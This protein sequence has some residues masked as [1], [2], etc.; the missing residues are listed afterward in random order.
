MPL[1]FLSN[2]ESDFFILDK[3][4]S[5]FRLKIQGNFNMAYPFPIGIEARLFYL[6]NRAH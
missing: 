6:E 3:A 1:H 5:E 4:G 2:T